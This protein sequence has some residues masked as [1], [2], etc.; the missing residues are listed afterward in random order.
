MSSLTGG[1]NQEIVL[2]ENKK[3]K[4]FIQSNKKK[5]FFVQI[6]DMELGD[7]LSAEL[8]KFKDKI[9][10]FDNLFTKYSSTPSDLDYIQALFHGV[11]ENYD[12]KSQTIEIS[13]PSEKFTILKKILKMNKKIKKLKIKSEI[14]KK[15]SETVANVIKHI[16]KAHKIDK[17]KSS[18][19]IKMIETIIKS[20]KSEKSILKDPCYTKLIDLAK[21]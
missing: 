11:I 15:V 8:L 1:S 19:L 21:L 13:E 5:T 3:I 18:S 6:L 12:P 4:T 10:N 7:H 9:S 14:K 20:G 2:Y 16:V 17:I